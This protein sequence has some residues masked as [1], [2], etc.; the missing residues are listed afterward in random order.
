MS[1]ILRHKPEAHNVQLSAEGWA[2][3]VNLLRALRVQYLNI[4]REDITM[5]VADNDKQRFEFCVRGCCI[6]ARHGHI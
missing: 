1:R 2:Q 4:T 5:V 3:T 6:K